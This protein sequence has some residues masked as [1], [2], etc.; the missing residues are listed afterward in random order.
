MGLKRSPGQ[1]LAEFNKVFCALRSKAGRYLTD[2][3]ATEAYMQAL[4]PQQLGTLVSA[5]AP[6]T[7]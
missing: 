6:A 3:A 7:L 4:Q 1:A 2:F 5:G